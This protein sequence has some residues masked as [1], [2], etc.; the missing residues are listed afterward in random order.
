MDLD[1]IP[2]G[3]IANCETT[4]IWQTKGSVCYK[5]HGIATNQHHIFSSER[6]VTCPLCGAFCSS[7]SVY[8]SHLRVIHAHEAGFQVSCG[9]QGCPRTFKNFYTYRNHVYSMHDLDDI[10]TNETIDDATTVGTTDVEMPDEMNLSTEMA[11]SSGGNF[12]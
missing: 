11:I 1:G 9:L 12:L 5:K 4:R 8:L 6:M 10:T 3:Y 7:I 2:T